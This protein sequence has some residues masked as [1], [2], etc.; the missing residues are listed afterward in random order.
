[1]SYI[2]LLSLFADKVSWTAYLIFKYYRVLFER[3]SFIKVL[4][5][6]LDNYG[7]YYGDHNSYSYGTAE[8]SYG[9][10]HDGRTWPTSTGTPHDGGGT[11]TMHGGGTLY[12]VMD[13]TLDPT[14]YMPTTT[15]PYHTTPRP[16]S[17]RPGKGGRPLGQGGSRAGRVLKA[18]RKKVADRKKG[19]KIGGKSKGRKRRGK[20]RSGGR[21]QRNKSR[22]RGRGLIDTRKKGKTGKSKK[23][24]RRKGKKQGRRKANRRKA[25]GRTKS[26]KR[27]K[28][29]I[30]VGGIE[31]KANRRKGKSQGRTKSSPGRKGSA[32][33][34]SRRT[35][36]KVVTP[37][38]VEMTTWTSEQSSTTQRPIRI[39]SDE[40][41][42]KGFCI[43]QA[44]EAGLEQCILDIIEENGLPEDF[45][46][47]HY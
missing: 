20:V 23:Q 11:G 14:T 15:P 22:K 30:I 42:L 4:L 7:D 5:I 39:P 32:G 6:F 8:W 10:T 19:K 2:Y 44:I 16:T 38:N 13:E 9:T 37:P 1:V 43:E 27:T 31:R 41:L 25:Q 35:I 29:R 40:N 26:S 28:P 45:E 12:D 47:D 33:T 18:A 36:L 34:R 17:K 46:D 21:R 24:G 3:S